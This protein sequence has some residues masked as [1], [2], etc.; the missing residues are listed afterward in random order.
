MAGKSNISIEQ[1][2]QFSA[3]I[4]SCESLSVGST[5]ERSLLRAMRQGSAVQLTPGHILPIHPGRKQIPGGV[6]RI[7]NNHL[8]TPRGWIGLTREV[9]QQTRQ[10][11]VRTAQTQHHLQRRPM[12]WFKKTTL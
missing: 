5:L 6:T 7:I 3:G 10:T 12:L 8:Q 9:F 1:H 4:Q 11:G 2:H